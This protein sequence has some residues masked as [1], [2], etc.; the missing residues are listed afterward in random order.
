MLRSLAVMKDVGSHRLGPVLVDVPTGRAWW[1]LPPDLC[2]ELDHVPHLTLKP[3][4]W[5]LACPP[6]LHAIDERI[7]LERPDGSGLLTD[8]RALCAAFGPA[9]R[10][11]AEA[12]R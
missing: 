7:W 4:G 12:F 6:V 2:N 5:P 1:L 9:E 11:P 8:P 10:F 3:P